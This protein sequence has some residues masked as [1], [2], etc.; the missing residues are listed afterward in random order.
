MIRTAFAP[1]RP[2]LVAVAALLTTACTDDVTAPP[3]SVAGTFTVD[4]SRSWV[5][6]SLADSAIVTPIPS[7]NESD[8]WDI[9]FNATN[10][11]LNGGAAGPGGVTAACLCQNASATGEQVL[12]MTAET[13]Q[14]DFDAVGS[15]P[16]GATF[17]SDELTP[18]ISGWYAG[19]GAAAVA[20]PD[21]AFL[22]RLSDSLAYA[23][24]R[25]TKLEGATAGSAGKVTLEYA[26][27]PMATSALGETKT[28]VVDLTTAGAK[29]VDLNTGA[30]TSATDWDL[31]LEGFTIKVNGGVSGPGKGG[32]AAATG[33]FADITTAVTAAQAYRTDVY[34]GAF[35]DTPYYRYN[36]AGDHRISPSFDVYLIKRGSAAYALQV[37]GYYGAT[38]QSRQITFRYK[39][40]S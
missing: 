12:A 1:L 32:A 5:Y 36:I 15:I 17:V 9:A 39:K 38:G 11:T 10:V 26:L 31:R 20:A 22:V 4:A 16:T 29:S 21:K 13:E 27:Q 28:L 19:N 14:A 25:V 30:V 34:A 7:A 40:I 8:A 24:V 35:A 2:A 23:K 18:A 6:V 33:S 37:V 3:A